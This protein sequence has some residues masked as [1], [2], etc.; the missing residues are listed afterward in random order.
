MPVPLDVPVQH[1]A[2]MG[3]ALA[4]AAAALAH[5]DV[6]IGAVV[7]G[8][9]GTVLGAGHNRREVDADPTAHAE[10]L[11]IRAA[12]ARL[13]R[14]RLDDCTLVVTLEPCAMCA[15]AAVLARLPRVVFGAWD[16]KAGASGSV[17]E[18]LREPRLN[19]WVQVYPRVREAEC[20]A[21]LRDFFA[22]HR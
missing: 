17:F 6:P 4:E 3:L 5:D 16:E 7:V 20:A 14:W 15:G 21:L 13:G 12:A 2:W 22:A 8:P 1:H 10:V 19:H 9:G 18:V 11:A